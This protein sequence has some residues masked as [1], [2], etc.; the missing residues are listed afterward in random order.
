VLINRPVQVRAAARDLDVGL[1]DEPPITG[2][3]AGRPS[4]VDELRRE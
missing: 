1:V 2:D 4:G 3:M